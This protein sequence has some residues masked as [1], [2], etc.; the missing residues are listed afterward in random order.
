MEA[1]THAA[2]AQQPTLILDPLS[3]T[4]YKVP[5]RALRYDAKNPVYMEFQSFERL[6]RT[7]QLS[8]ERLLHHLEGKTAFEASQV[9][10]VQLKRNARGGPPLYAWGTRMVTALPEEIFPD[11]EQGLVGHQFVWLWPPG[12]AYN[13]FLSRKEKLRISGGDAVT[14]PID[15][16]EPSCRHTPAFPGAMLGPEDVEGAV[17]VPH[18]ELTPV[19]RFFIMCID[20]QRTLFPRRPMTDLWTS[21]VTNIVNRNQELARVG[22]KWELH[23]SVQR[24]LKRAESERHGGGN[25]RA[26]RCS[27]NESEIMDVDALLNEKER[28]QRQVREAERSRRWAALPHELLV[29]I[30]CERLGAGIVLEGDA[31]D[32]ICVLRS[33][34][35]GARALVD[36]FIGVQLANVIEATFEQVV[37]S[38]KKSPSEPMT[39]VAARVRALGLGM[40]D[41]VSLPKNEVSLTVVPHWSLPNAPS[42][43][44]DWRWYLELRRAAQERHGAKPAATRRWKTR[45]A[46][47]EAYRDLM[48]AHRVAEPEVWGARFTT[49]GRFE[50]DFDALVAATGDLELQRKMLALAGVG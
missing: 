45:A 2:A 6:A 13:A 4:V 5:S 24:M 17:L 40:R 23:N 12:K 26:K 39:A 48:A 19:Q 1:D 43:V 11:V 27:D 7:Q 33:V 38:S 32:T 35:K 20:S 16:I 46:P 36:S 14:A 50:H 42:V 37:M 49:E 22:G 15:E 3:H 10:V 29:R 9:V 18:D 34:S 28:W 41:I 25:K 31:R 44:P 21:R 47:A 8:G 30:L